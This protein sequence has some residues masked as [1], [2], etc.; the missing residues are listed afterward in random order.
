MRLAIAQRLTLAHGIRG[1]M[2]VQAQS[3]AE[4]LLARGHEVLILTTPHP[5]GRK[6]GEEGGVPV[7]YIGPGS[8]RRYDRRWWAACYRELA[9]IHNLQPFNLLVS[10]SAGALG[11]LPRAA[12]E[13][14]LPTVVVM[15]GTITGGLRTHWQAARTPRGFYRLARL[16]TIQPYHFLLWW[17]AAR[18]ADHWIAVSAEVADEWQ[19]EMNLP[20][21]QITVVPNGVDTARFRPDPQT[22][23]AT[24][25]ALSIAA[26]VPLL[27]ATGRLVYEKG[28][29]VAI[30]ALRMLR[31]RFPTAQLLIIGNGNYR[32]VLERE[33]AD[34]GDAVRFA[35][36]IPNHELPTLLAVAD[37]FLMP[38]SVLR[39]VSNDDC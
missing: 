2:E 9:R 24:R 11:Y 23:S 37:I 13:L 14:R 4:G 25:A 35:G 12:S 39:G 17:R 38:T 20:P 6:I 32:Q 27:L 15:H 28:F 16:L 3:L 10:Q 26:E 31:S 8:Y 5:D 33:A 1:G 34:L 21:E 29:H 36:Y 30:A 19:R 18:S 22:R 7:R